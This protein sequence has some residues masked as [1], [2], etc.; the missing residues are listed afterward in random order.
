MMPR[1]VGTVLDPD[2]ANHIRVNRG[3]AG[4]EAGAGARSAAPHADGG[5]ACSSPTMR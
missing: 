3:G 5:G 2:M 4:P 1:L